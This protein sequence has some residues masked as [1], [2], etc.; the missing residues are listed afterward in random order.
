MNTDPIKVSQALIN[1]MLRLTGL[2]PSTFGQKSGV[3]P[4]TVTRALK[5][6]LKGGVDMKTLVRLADEAG[7]E[8]TLSR[9]HNHH[10]S[11]IDVELIRLATETTLIALTDEPD[12]FGRLP[13]AIA[14]MCVWIVDQRQGGATITTSSEAIARMGT[15]ARHLGRGGSQA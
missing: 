4:S 9:N 7:V 3:S 1:Q 15:L 2:K 8:L 6:D 5:G 12:L 10:G 13:D 11:N 14:E